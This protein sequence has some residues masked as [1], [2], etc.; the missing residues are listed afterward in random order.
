MAE[1]R[2]AACHAARRKNC[3]HMEGRD[4]FPNHMGDYQPK[5]HGTTFVLDEDQEHAHSTRGDFTIRIPGRRR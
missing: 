4:T 2:C 3:T 1:E 5:S